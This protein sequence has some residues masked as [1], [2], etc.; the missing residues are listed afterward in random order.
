MDSDSDAN[1]EHYLS[2][3]ILTKSDKKP[4]DDLRAGLFAF[5][6]RQ[7]FTDVTLIVESREIHCHRNVLAAMSP[8]FSTMFSCEFS[9]KY[10]KQISLP[11]IEKFDIMST[12]LKY[13]YTGDITFVPKEDNILLL[14]LA[15]N[16]LQLDSLV[17]L[18]IS[19]IVLSMDETNCLLMLQFA[20]KFDCVPVREKAKQII[21]EDFMEIS[22]QEEFLCLD[23]TLIREIVQWDELKIDNELHLLEC[24]L[25]W[26]QKE[27]VLRPDQFSASLLN[28]VKFPS[29]DLPGL[30]SALSDALVLKTLHPVDICKLKRILKYP[31]RK[32][33]T[34]LDYACRKTF[35]KEECIAALDFSKR[36][37]FQ[38][39]ELAAENKLCVFNLSCGLNRSNCRL[40]EAIFFAGFYIIEFQ[41]VTFMY[42]LFCKKVTA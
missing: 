23:I 21:C 24:C 39:F 2:E 41:N 14:Y 9:E 29:L 26:L 13:M 34:D 38:D 33:E 11:Y 36:K 20:L 8:F 37:N 5:Y 42:V 12:V 30:K 32:G 17:K 18:C 16:F 6:E 28:C 4:I 35:R 10:Q 31:F 22:K 40:P 3:K 19:F 25:N 15:A 7:Q 27:D 1:S